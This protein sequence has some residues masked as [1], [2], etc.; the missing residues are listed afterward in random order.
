MLDTDDKEYNIRS[1]VIFLKNF[2]VGILFLKLVLEILKCLT[3][4]DDGNMINLDDNMDGINIYDL[5]SVDNGLLSNN[6]MI[7]RT[8]RR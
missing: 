7:R 5:S 6:G 1:T 8:T 2:V 3:D 4:D